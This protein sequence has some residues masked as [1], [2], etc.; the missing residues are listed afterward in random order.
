MRKS[1]LRLGALAASVSTVASLLVGCGG[2][3]EAPSDFCKSVDAL[4]AAVKQI[5]Q[6]SLSKNSIEA[7]ET[8]MA[9]LDKAVTNLS[10][11]VESEF[12]TEVNAVESAATEL[13]DTVSTAV[14]NPDPANISAARTSMSDLTTAVNELDKATSDSC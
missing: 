3:G 14:D 7:V 6:T 1:R 5:N 10:N 13:G 9:T 4:A 8:S 2:G 12:S 11:T